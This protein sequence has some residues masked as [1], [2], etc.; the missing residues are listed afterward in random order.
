MLTTISHGGGVAF[1]DEIQF[2][3]PF[4]YM[5]PHLARSEACLLPVDEAT[6]Y[7]LLLLGEAMADPGTPPDTAPPAGLAEE[8]RRFRGEVVSGPVPELDSTTMAS[9][10]TYLGQF[11]DHDITAN[12]DREIGISDIANLDGSAKPLTPLDPAQVEAGLTNGRRAHLDLDSVYGDGPGL[13]PRVSTTA[14][15]LYEDDGSLLLRLHDQGDVFDLPRNG[16]THRAVIADMRNDENVIVG[17]LHAAILKSHNKVVSLL[18]SGD[19]VDDYVRARQLIRWAYQ[20]VVLYD[21]LPTVCDTGV[22]KDVL[23]NGPRFFSPAVSGGTLF[24]PLEFSVAGFRFGHSMIRPFYELNDDTTET[25]DKLLEGRSRVDPNTGQLPK[26][27]VVDWQR[28]TGD[29]PVNKARRIDAKL[30]AGLFNLPFGPDILSRLAQRNLLRGYL[31]G[32]PTGQAVAHA[33]GIQPL[34]EE[35][36][37]CEESSAVETAFNTGGFGKRTPLWYYILKE[38]EIQKEGNSLGAVG[39]RIVAETLIGL[40]KQDPIGVLGAHDSKVHAG[41]PDQG[42]GVD[43]EGT[44]ITTIESLLRF[45]GRLPNPGAGHKSA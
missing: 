30:A 13:I 1:E 21:Y 19:A 4:G 32:L 27:L 41:T 11:I 43:L 17:Q 33:M 44:K 18:S 23:A 3:T 45:A 14:Q 29:D 12:T 16:K 9:V 42:G 36:L 22:V 2:R 31:L 26:E 24:M 5:F 34:A 20:Y 8:A 39:S 37:L 6:H 38:A 40:V 7:G 15:E 25:I 28:F 35:D 10:F